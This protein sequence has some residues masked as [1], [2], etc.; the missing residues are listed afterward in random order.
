MYKTF[1]DKTSMT[2]EF[3]DFLG[4][5]VLANHHLILNSLPF[6]DH[7]WHLM[8]SEE[9]CPILTWRPWNYVS[10]FFECSPNWSWIRA[11]ITSTLSLRF[12]WERS[13]SGLVIA[14]NVRRD[15]PQPTIFVRSFS[16]ITRCFPLNSKPSMK[17]IT[18]ISTMLWLFRILDDARGEEAAP[19][20]TFPTPYLRETSQTSVTTSLFGERVRDTPR[21]THLDQQEVQPWTSELHAQDSQSDTVLP[22]G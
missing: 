11:E 17:E 8:I 15:G 4:K 7:M 12:L 21:P 20:R 22:K 9:N 10:M 13:S 2:G 18:A 14:L 3:S 16:A 1:A 6:E 19:H 5:A